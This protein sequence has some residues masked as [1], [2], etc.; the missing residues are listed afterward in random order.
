MHGNL[1][2]ISPLPAP[3]FLDPAR[4]KMAINPGP[5]FLGEKIQQQPKHSKKTDFFY[6]RSQ[7][8]DKSK[9]HTVGGLRFAPTAPAYAV[10]SHAQST[11]CSGN[12]GKSFYQISG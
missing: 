7:R 1:I 2:C 3:K 11:G 6:L 9:F 12:A 4:V 5:S 10:H 8:I